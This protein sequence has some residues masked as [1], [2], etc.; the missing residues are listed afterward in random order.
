MPPAHKFTDEWLLHAALKLPGVTPQAVEKLRAGGQTG[1]AKALIQGGLARPEDIAQT[2]ADTYGVEFLD[3]NSSMVQREAQQLVPEKVCRKHNL[4]PVEVR[5]EKIVVA[6]ADPISHDAFADVQASSG[7]SPIP[8]YCPLERMVTLIAEIFSPDLL[9]DGIVG[10][11]AEQTTVEVLEGSSKE[12]EDDTP[13]LVRAPVIRLANSIIS[14]AVK[15]RASDIHIEH[16]ERSSS[17]RY[18]IDGDLRNVMALPRSIAATGLVSRIKIMS[19]LDLTEHRRPQDGR[20]KLRVSGAEI[21]LRVS[22]L[23]TAFGEKVV[24]RILDKRAAEVPYEKLGF[25]PEVSARI[26]ALLKTAQGTF[27]VTGPTGSGK[28][29]TLYSI[30]NRLKSEDTNIVTVEDPIEYKLTGINQV[31]VNEKQGLNFA[32]V[33]RSVL[34]QDPDI[35]LVGEIRDQETA[36]IAFQAAL[37]GHLVLS[38]LH[39]ND[40]L[41]SIARLVDM[42]VEPFKIAPGLIA[43]TAQ[44][45]VRRLC[46][47][48]RQELAPDQLDPASLS[49]LRQFNQHL[50]GF[51]ASGCEHC[52]FSGFKGRLSIIE[53]LEVSATLKARIMSG[54]TEASLRRHALESGDLWP[55]TADAAWHL[56]QGDTTFEELAPYLRASDEKKQQAPA[57]PAAAAPAPPV[58]P[59]APALVPSRPSGSAAKRILVADDEKA[60]RF[61]LRQL[62]QAEGFA[63]DEAADGLQALERLTASPP[64]LL[65]LDLNMPNLDGHGVLRAL[66]QTLGLISLPVIIITT[67]TDD[68]SQEE[69]F[70]AGADDYVTKPFRANMLMVRVKAALKRQELR[71]G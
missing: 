60:N 11:L 7:R 66:R 50:R 47:H 37:T 5:G 29:T 49:L 13:E 38:T 6:M 25:K 32:G 65:L 43:I 14:K 1:L 17:V 4:L 62:L 21:G 16:E 19:D 46:P 63:V 30:L 53:L 56:S 44:R 8:Y 23:P 28:T 55:L 61:I 57:L 26:D 69:A 33:L 24:I 31:Q 15:M 71:Q 3:L 54:D 10:Q 59:A 51:K 36:D 52:E 22:T 64:D 27:L 48:C 41:S 20:A 58:A 34:R 35:I 39:T 42:G 68:K 40:T 2:A 67:M 12:S 45:L 18:R 70:G 9:I